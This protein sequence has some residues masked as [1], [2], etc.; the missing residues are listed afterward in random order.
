MDLT[1]SYLGLTLRN[2]VVASSSP[3]TAD[4]DGVRR[5]SDA[6]AGAIVLP[7]LFE[8]QVRHEELDDH[9]LTES[10]AGVFG[11]AQT[12]FPQAPS[13]DLGGAR[14]HLTFVE[15]AVAVSEVPVIGSL[16][17]S[18]PGGWTRIAKGFEDAGVAA[19]ELNI[20]AVPGGP[21]T[22]G[23]QVERRHEDIV[24]SVCASVSIPVSV[25]LSPYFSATGAMAERIVDAG[26]VGLV[27]FNRFLQPDIDVERLAVIPNA[28][29]SSPGEA[30]LPR[31]WI[32]I[33]RHR[34][35]ASL[36]G[37][38]GVDE[39]DDVVAYLLAGADV[40][41]TASALLRYGPGHAGILVAGLEEWLGRQ[42]Y[43]SVSQA[44]G[45]LAVRPDQD[46]AQYER[47]GYVAALRHASE[48]YGSLH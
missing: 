37:T 21:Y 35:H 32:A 2:P 3:L 43:S 47:T 41:M 6:G 16:N 46:A 9:L 39:A 25:K 38:S 10:H 4:L 30:R 7:S 29:L 14:A 23:A 8:E 15:R 33:L 28:V 40:V 11:E 1:T 13:V 42:G 24:A 18:S 20:Y 26:A 17:G 44:R 22:S 12:Y 45:L 34:L 19:L 48:V 36:A 31:T 27:L 5:V